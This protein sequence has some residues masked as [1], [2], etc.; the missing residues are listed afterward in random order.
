MPYEQTGETN[1]SRVEQQEDK[2]AAD[3]KP[4]TSIN[5]RLVWVL[6]IACAMTAANVYYSQPLLADI[7]RAFAASERA[8]G[9]IATLTQLGF[10]LGLLLLVPLGDTLDRRK[11]LTVLLLAVSLAAIANA[12][13]PTLLVLSLASFALGVT[14]VV[15][16]VIVPLAASL[17]PGYG[18]GR[19]IG[20]VMSSLMIGILLA[21][22]ISGAVGAALGWRSMYIIAAVLMLILLVILR[23]MLPAEQP[24]PGMNYLQLLRSL[25]VF[26]RTEPIVREVSLLGGMAFGA[27]S[28]FWVALPFF[29]G[30]PP[31]HYGSAVVGLFGLVGVAGALSA[32]FA[33]RLSERFDARITTGL[34]VVVSALSFL[35]FWLFGYQLW[36][37]ITGVIL[38]DIGTQAIHI[39]N[40]TRIYSLRAEAH[41]RLNTVYMVSYFVGGSLGSTLGAYGWSVA[42]WTGVCAAGLSMLSVA[43]LAYAIGSVRRMRR[44]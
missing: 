1:V 15:P 8:V 16:Q 20:T 12:A 4:V 41:S 5:W 13:A 3:E 6:A 38:L 28:V 44:V 42:H 26:I 40:Q 18:R 32:S 34:M 14:T 33:G 22:T 24:R 17:A 43:L 2:Q 37:L 25:G 31:Y 35:C 27:F 10:A 7:G 21:R 23:I 39:S 29:L 11:L 9:F 36:G 19:V 30:T